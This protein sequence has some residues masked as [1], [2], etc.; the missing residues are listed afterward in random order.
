ML[1]TIHASIAI[2]TLL[3]VVYADEQALRWFMGKTET[4]KASRVKLL[5]Y[6]VTA[7]LA[8]LIIT[9]GLLYKDLATIYVSIPTFITKMTMVL[10][11]ILNTYAIERFSR[12]ALT[13]SFASLSPRERVP[14][15]ISGAVSGGAWATAFICGL[16]L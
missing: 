8:L 6:L 15:F 12:V 7:G 11:L 14:L 4:V 5:H 3:A 1:V 13:R 10:A 2:A 9:G 16:L